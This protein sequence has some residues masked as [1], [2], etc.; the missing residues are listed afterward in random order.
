MKHLEK[1][2]TCKEVQDNREDWLFKLQKQTNELNYWL[3]S[4]IVENLVAKPTLIYYF[5]LRKSEV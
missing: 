5:D 2:F 4:Q 1:R 3:L